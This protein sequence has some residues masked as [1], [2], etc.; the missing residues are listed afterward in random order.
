MV[1]NPPYVSEGE[2]NALPREV[3]DFEPPGALL[4]GPDGLSVIRRL[5][6]G[7]ADYLLPGGAL[8]CEIGETQGEAVR[9][10]PSGLLSFEGVAADLAGRDR[11]ALWKKSR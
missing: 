4:A 11:V 3:R 10:L 8:L 1:S 5:V 9:R 6:A 7:A 2:W